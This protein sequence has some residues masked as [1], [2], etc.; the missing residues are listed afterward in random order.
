MDDMVAT[1][2]KSK[3][4][5]VW[6]LK[7][8]LALAF[9]AA[10]G[11]KVAGVPAMVVV[12]TKIGFGQ[13]FRILTGLLEM[14]GAIGLL[15]PRFAFYAAVLLTVVMIGAI[16]FHLT[17]LGGNPTPPVVLLALSALTAWLIK[18]ADRPESEQA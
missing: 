1:Q 10:G 5:G 18:S 6:T 14:A 2:S 4:I 13:W 9:L 11:S 15:V 16:G 8:L 12:F 3:V 17:S 7:V